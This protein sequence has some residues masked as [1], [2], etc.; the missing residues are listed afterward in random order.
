MTII[1]S[2]PFVPDDGDRAVAQGRTDRADPSMPAF[3]DSVAGSRHKAGGALLRAD[4]GHRRPLRPGS[5]GLGS[6]GPSRHPARR[7]AA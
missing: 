7:S 2:R 5:C 6:H 4:R 1:R 3:A